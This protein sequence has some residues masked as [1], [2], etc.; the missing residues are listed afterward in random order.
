[1]FFAG[2]YCVKNWLKNCQAKV[3]RRMLQIQD[4]QE[5]PKNAA[6]FLGIGIPEKLPSA[7]R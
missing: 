2:K 6:H 1:M 7:E 3:K 4:L 5:I